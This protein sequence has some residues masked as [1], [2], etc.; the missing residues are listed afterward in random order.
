[1]LVLQH[2]SV[3]FAPDRKV[4]TNSHKKKDH[5]VLKQ[6]VQRFRVVY[7]NVAALHHQA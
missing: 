5:L 3:H 6:V 2:F 1:M 4:D 7:E